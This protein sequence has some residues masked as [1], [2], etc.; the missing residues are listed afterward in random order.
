MPSP[1]PS[2]SP[3]PASIV[4]VAAAPHGDGTFLAPGTFSFGANYW[5][6][7]AGTNM[8][9]DWDADVVA[10]DFRRVRAAGMDVLRVFPL[11]PDFQPIH[12]LYAGQN[13]FRCYALADGSPLPNREGL[14]PVMIDRFNT[15]C[16]LAAEARVKL[17]VGLV[18]GW[19][20]G[21]MF[22]PPGLSHMDPITNPEAIQWQ[23]RLC[24]GIIAQT[25]HQ[26]AI[27]AWDLGNECNEM[28]DAP[29]D[30]A[31]YAWTA[32]VAGSI[33]AAD[34]TRP[35]V[36]GMHTLSVE[37]DGRWRIR[38]QGELTDLLTTHPYPFWVTHAGLDATDTLRP[39]CHATAETRL[40]A[41]LGG[42]PAFAEEIG[43]M[44]PTVLDDARSA[45]FLRASAWSLYAHDCR[46][47]LWWCAFDQE[48]L[49]HPPYEWVAVERQLG[50]MRSDGSPKP[51]L[52]A[53]TQMRA[54]I[55]ALP[56]DALPERLVD[57]TVLLTEGQDQ[58][59][60]AFGA[61]VMAR[62]AGLS[63]RFSTWDAPLPD[64]AT[65]PLLIVP[66]VKGLVALPASLQR[67]L[68]G[69][70]Q[71][72]GRVLLTIDDAHLNDLGEVWGLHLERRHPRPSGDK[73]AVV[74]PGFQPG[75][76]YTATQTV[77]MQLKPAGAEV[78]AAEADG[79]PVLTRHAFGEKGGEAW[80]LTLPLEHEL[81]VTPGALGP[82][83]DRPFG[84][85]YRA[86]AEGVDTGRVASQSNPLVGLTEHPL[87][88]DVR[89]LVLVNAGNGPADC[90]LALADDWSVRD[91]PRGV[92]DGQTVS[93]PPHDAAA[94]CL[95]RG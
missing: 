75:D 90:A 17:I 18:T 10:D 66:S 5:A 42:R 11:W 58:W 34:P 85:V 80:L 84:G 88:S 37:G 49:T 93:V 44:G 6:S 60:V 77:R 61:F 15:M 2:P 57:A 69:F 76:R 53:M 65:T 48:K 72:G 68:R 87:S 33:K 8:W 71:A 14:D 50:L 54:D 26:P 29:T 25:K 78:L 59:A 21:R 94:I 63:P 51:V 1:S 39:I 45:A 56:F 95:K 55:D 38:H 23:V 9:S 67:A 52:E 7:H 13:S 12:R 4:P 31:A 43:S 28:G 35:L 89:V 92:L 74:L 62:Q 22:M 79:N 81:T 86:F 20:S 83:H 3:G 82:A 40:Y 91:A 47:A 73:L 27:A 32:A 64:P 19:M 30:A 41:D 46:A 36:S 24:R 16:A 70:V